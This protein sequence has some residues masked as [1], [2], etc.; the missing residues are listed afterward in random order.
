M[1]FQDELDDGLDK[2]ENLVN[3]RGDGERAEFGMHDLSGSSLIDAVFTD[4]DLRGT[5]RNDTDFRGP[6]GLPRKFEEDEE[7]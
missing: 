3:G 4:A 7:D 6:K 5:N 1:T 2:H